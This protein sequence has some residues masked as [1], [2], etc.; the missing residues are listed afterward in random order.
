MTRSSGIS[1]SWMAFAIVFWKV[2]F[3]WARSWADGSTLPV[4]ALLF[5]QFRLFKIFLVQPSVSSTVTPNS[6]SIS[7][8]LALITPF[9]MFMSICL[10]MTPPDIRV[11]NK[12]G[13][14]PSHLTLCLTLNFIFGYCSRACLDLTITVHIFCW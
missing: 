11:P 13:I 6:L 5:D 8:L 3:S 2:K 14:C 12:Q 9:P 10:L 4:A 7:G 1:S